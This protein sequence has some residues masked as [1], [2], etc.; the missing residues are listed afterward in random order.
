MEPRRQIDLR[1]FG[2]RQGPSTL[3]RKARSVQL[4]LTRDRSA[5]REF[6]ADDRPE[7]MGLFDRLGFVRDLLRVTNAVRG[8]HSLAEMLALSRE[9]LARSGRRE[10]TVVEAGCGPGGSTAKL[11]L[12]TRRA[13]GELHAFDSFRGIPPNDE[14]HEHLDGRPVVFRAKAFRSTL[15]QVRAAVEAFGAPEVCV[16]HRGLF[17]ETLPA[18][19]RPIDVC[20]LDVDLL[21]S[22]RTCLV[23]LFPRLRPDGVMFTQDGHL[24]AIVDLLG[25]ESF[26]RDEVGVRPPIIQGLGRR[27]LLELRPA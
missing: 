1:R 13:G 5:L 12:A 18:F 22:T 11:S 24:R 19:R 9:I 16:Y 20:L 6:L 8:Y 15:K 14:R 7:T 2:V 10:L 27:K 4:L 26:W 3:Y 25:D 23:E 21:T 17:A